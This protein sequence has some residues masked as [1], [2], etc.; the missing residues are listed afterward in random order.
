MVSN[1]KTVLIVEDELLIRLSLVEE[2]EYAGFVVLEAE[3]ADDALEVLNAYPKIE[4]IFTD[5][6]MPGSMNG[7]ELA[8]LVHT[9]R[10]EMAI[11][12]TSGFLK[13]PKSELPARIPFVPKPYDVSRV[14][15]H[16]RELILQRGSKDC[17]AEPFKP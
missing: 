7:V 16:I 3:T 14:I 8:E 1:S 4:A 12:L 9:I 13:V 6:D 11:M 2:L 17:F 10:P 15:N 5:I